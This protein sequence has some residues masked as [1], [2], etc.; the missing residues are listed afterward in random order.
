MNGSSG[1]V[2][3]FSTLHQARE[4]GIENAKE[5]LERS[6]KQ[7][8]EDVTISNKTSLKEFKELRRLEDLPVD[9]QDNIYPIVQ[10]TNGRKVVFSPLPMHLEDAAGHLEATRV[11]VWPAMLHVH[12][13]RPEYSI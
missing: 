4:V 7:S 9:A 13:F 2:L 5:I 8:L 11:Q 10:F 1:R 12:S 6:L 3:G